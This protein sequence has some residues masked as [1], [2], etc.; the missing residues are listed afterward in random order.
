MLVLRF[1]AGPIVHR[2]SPLGLLCISAA[3]AACGLFFLSGATGLYILAAATLYGVGK[4][5]FW[6]T[7]LGVVSEQFPRGG[8]LTLNTIAG[9]GMLSVG[10]LGAPFLGFIQDSKI[11]RDLATANPAVHAQLAGETKQS[12][13]GAYKSLD[14]KKVEELTGDSKREVT[15]IQ[16]QA[17]RNVLFVVATFPCIMLAAYIGLILYFKSKGGYKAKEL[18]SEKEEE[19]IMTGGAA[20][21]VEY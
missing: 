13:F 7:M 2:L 21:A 3:V 15:D 10:V 17:K 9:L 1:F 20:G 5:F 4:T 18:I 19:A 16:D 12:V 8:A 11:D 14:P 6:P